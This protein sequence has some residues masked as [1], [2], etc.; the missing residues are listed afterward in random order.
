MTASHVQL[1]EGCILTKGNEVSCQESILQII[2]S[3]PATLYF[4]KYVKDKV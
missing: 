1:E 4:F 2:P 3:M